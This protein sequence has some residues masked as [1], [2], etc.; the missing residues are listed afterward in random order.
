MTI[1]ANKRFNGALAVFGLGLLA[2]YL[3]PYRTH[4]YRSYYQDAL[5]LLGLSLAWALTIYQRR[6]MRLSS[7]LVLPLI[8]LLLLSLQLSL[9]LIPGAGALSFPVLYFL[10]LILALTLGSSWAD[11]PDGAD[12]ICLSL[13]LAHLAA[14]LISVAL[15]CVQLAGLDATPF[16]MGI[17]HNAHTFLRPYANVAQP[18]QL[19]LLLCLALAS[20]WW[21]HQQGRMHGRAVLALAATL[22]WGL[23]LTQ[24]RIGWI[25]VPAFAVLCLMPVAAGRAV[26][27]VGMSVLVLLYAAFVLGLP[28]LAQALGFAGGSLAEHVGGRSERMALW[29]Q[30]WRMAAQHPWLG[31]GWGGYGAEQVKI[32]ADFSAGTYAEHAH[33]LI[34]N[35]AAELGWPATLL[36][37][38]GLGWWLWQTCVLPAQ[39]PTLR[40][41]SLC[42]AAVLV[43]SMVEFPLWY[44]YVLIPVGVL[45]GMLHQLRW[46]AAGVRVGVEPAAAIAAL[47]LA[48]A[49]GW[50]ISWDY[51]RVVQG[52]RALGQELA[53]YQVAPESMQMPAY[54]LFPQF[55]EYFRLMK[56][57]P[58][59]GMAQDEIAYV[60]RWS[61]RFGFVH[62]LNKLAEVYVLNGQPQQAGRVMLTLQRLHPFDYPEY[63]DYWQ[64]KAA[65]DARYRVVFQRM[66][67]REAP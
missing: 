31:V 2:A 47:V 16:V 33:N 55:Y 67:P 26:S 42:L 65:L 60:E 58:R 32:A 9:G 29:Q 49:L 41:A 44:A 18:N 21:L 38:G 22:L 11:Q 27:R 61:R 40:F 35:F 39:S 28:Y 50:A 62:I 7:L 1:I 6:C 46:P 17:A 30:A 14:G 43:H 66:P 13:A 48:A 56:V 8:L 23:A 59:A 54:T 10:F 20:L 53:G 19:A 57:V 36:F 15:Q 25:I 37:I 12:K 5:V 52:F 64:A 24:S 4:P 34:L 45:L 3:H 63:Y 51:R